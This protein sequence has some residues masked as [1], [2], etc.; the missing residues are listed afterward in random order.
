MRAVPLMCS[1]ISSR[2]HAVAPVFRVGDRRRVDDVDK[3]GW[4]GAKAH[5]AV[6]GRITG[7]DERHV[8]ATDEGR[9]RWVEL[10]QQLLAVEPFGPNGCA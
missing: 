10:A 9:H 8:G 2:H 5:V 3:P 1:P 4:P 6:P 7:G